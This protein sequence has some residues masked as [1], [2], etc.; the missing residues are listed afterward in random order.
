MAKKNLQATETKV[1]ETFNKMSESVDNTITEK[2][3]NIEEV[4]PIVNEEVNPIVDTT[5]DDE[6]KPIVDE[7]VDDEVKPIVDTT[8][9]NEVK[10]AEKIQVPDIYPE[11]DSPIISSKDE[12]SDDV[13]SDNNESDDEEIDEEDYREFKKEQIETVEK[14]K[15]IFLT[16]NNYS[17]LNCGRHLKDG[18]TIESLEKFYKE[19]VSYGVSSDT[20]FAVLKLLK[21]L[22]D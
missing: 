8:V 20:D 16:V 19:F 14:L 13:E 5:V 7:K 4:N 6:V 22:F 11:V 18:I 17:F 21:E 1:E 2:V 9:D 10:S 15:K 3:D 12:E